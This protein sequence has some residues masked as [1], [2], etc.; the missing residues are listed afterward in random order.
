MARIEAGAAHGTLTNRPPPLRKR[1][2]RSGDRPLPRSYEPPS[3]YDVA[4]GRHDSVKPEHLWRLTGSRYQK[5][6]PP[7]PAL[8]G[9]T[10]A[11]GGGAYPGL[12]PFFSSHSRGRGSGRSRSS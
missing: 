3:V 9:L 2:L 1:F 10:G 7:A 11:P 12:K 8:R 6:R 5:A 4:D